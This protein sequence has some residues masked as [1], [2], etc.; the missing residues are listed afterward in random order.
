[1]KE[2]VKTATNQFY[3]KKA[4]FFRCPSYEK[5]NNDNTQI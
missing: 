4:I 2:M 1:M 5:L 3:R